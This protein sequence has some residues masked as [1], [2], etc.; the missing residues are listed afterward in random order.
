MGNITVL[1][2]VIPT[3]EEMERCLELAAMLRSLL[4]GFEGFKREGRENLIKSY[5]IT[6]CSAIRSCSSVDRVYAPD[7]SNKAL[8]R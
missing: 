1:F 6:V 7:D 4:P 5:S 2:E 3:K 8:L